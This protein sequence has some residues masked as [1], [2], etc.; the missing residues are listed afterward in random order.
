MA[1]SP[2]ILRSLAVSLLGPALLACA[3]NSSRGAVTGPVRPGA[4]VHAYVAR[5]PGGTAERVTLT[6]HLA[7]RDVALASYQGR[8]QFDA[9]ALDVLEVTAPDGDGTRLVNASAAGEGVIRFV[10][11]AERGFA[12]TPALQLVVRPRRA[13]DEAALLPVL[14]VVGDA[15]GAAVPADRLSATPG[16]TTP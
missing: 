7:T 9:A 10:G 2:T 16:V 14:E 12:R 6:L 13:L 11:Y 15:D 1:T 4:G 3:E 5:E 8:L